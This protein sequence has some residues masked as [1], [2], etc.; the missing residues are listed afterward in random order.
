MR[1]TLETQLQE[2]PLDVLIRGGMV[3]DGTG[4]PGVPADVGIQGD[5]VVAVGDLRDR[6]AARILEANGHYVA[7]GFIDIHTHSDISLLFT[8][9]MES[10]LSQG[11]TSEIVG[12]CGISLGLAQKAEAFSLEQ[13]GL[14]RFGLELDWNNLSTFLRR[15]EENG[16]SLN[17]ATLAGH[18]TLRKR[19]MDLEPRLPDVGELAT[20]QRD[21]ETALEQGA[22]GLSSGLEYVPGMYADIPE[23]TALAKVAR[24]AGGFYATHLRDEGDLLE[25]S[26]EEAIAV[27]EGAGIPLQL[28]HHKSEKPRNWGKVLRTLATVEAARER[29]VDVLLDQYPYTAYQTG[30]ATIALPAWAVGG[31][32]QTLAEKLRMPENR[33]KVRAAMGGMDWAMVEIA[34]C[35]PHPEYIGKS[36]ETL[37]RGS[38]SSPEDWVLDLLS[39][40]EAWVSAVHFAL[41]P[42]DVERVLADGRVMVGSDAVAT[43]PEGP[44]V[45]DRPHPRSYGTFVRVLGHYVREKQLLTWE[46]AIRRMTSLPAQRLGW[47]DRGYLRTGSVADIVV[48]NPLTVSDTATFT[49]PH[50]FAVGIEYVLV[51]GTVAWGHGKPTGSRT[52]KVLRRSP[53]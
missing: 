42:E 43:H 33:A 5:R 21:L 48:F 46:E 45:S 9:G 13:R 34:S 12:N 44:S 2:T 26:V 27:A 40:G 3:F 10:S 19:A 22:I 38:R 30:L 51:G 15:I 39:E 18:G 41:S 29:G 14:S 37:A 8:P 31:T 52:G 23:L 17:V 49:H 32:P 35:P 1:A 36:V 28:S 11:V 4:T 6:P 47:T 25:E 16:I 20:M 24:D 7:P 53:A 50:S